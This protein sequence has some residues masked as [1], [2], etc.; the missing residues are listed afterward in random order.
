MLRTGS[1]LHQVSGE[2]PH[3]KRNGESFVG[4]LGPKD[5]R[6]FIAQNFVGERALD[7]FH[8]TQVTQFGTSAPRFLEE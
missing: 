5:R 3:T 2:L 6:H 4:C 8:L 7:G 1:S